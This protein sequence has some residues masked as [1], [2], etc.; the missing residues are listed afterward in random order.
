MRSMFIDPGALRT[1]MRLEA[2]VAMQDGAGGYTSSWQEVALVFARIEPAV[3]VVRHADQITTRQTHRVTIRYRQD[4][5]TGMRLTRAGRVFDV[6][7]V[8]DPDESGRYIV[9]SAREDK[10]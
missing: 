2:P 1:E 5:A 9:I 3:P 6:L 7:A 4:V 10:P 8:H